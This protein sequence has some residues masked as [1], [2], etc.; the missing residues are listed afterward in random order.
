MNKILLSTAFISLFCLPSQA[1]SL[2]QKYESQ[3]TDPLTYTCYRAGGD[4]KIDGKLTESS[5]QKAIPTA[6]FADISGKGFAKPK[7]T[8]TAKIL[9]D[10]NYLYIGAVIKE[11]DIE[12][13]LTHRDDIVF[14]DNDFEI[15]L[16]PDGDGTEYFEI[17]TNAIGTIFDL[18]LDRAYRSN[19]NFFTQWNCPGIKLAVYRKGT[20]NN[21]ADE[22]DYWSV[23]IAIPHD[24][25]K[26][27]FNN[28]LKQSRCW[29]LNFSR[30][31][32]LKKKGPEENW[33]WSPTGKID[34][35]MPERWGYVYLVDAP[36]GSP[37]QTVA[38]PYNKWIYKLLWAM[39]YAQQ[40]YYG[41][42]HHYLNS[43]NDFA[44]TDRELG[45]L[46]K[47]TQVIDE[48]TQNTF[49]IRITD[50]ENKKCYRLNNEGKFTIDKISNVNQ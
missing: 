29:R 18:L 41:T 16:D 20:L 13:K 22:D 36:V 21:A 26:V 45:N 33:V 24:A 38:L 46:P 30:V 37:Q 1:Q 7:Y 17:E 49:E 15:F 4:I 23:E 50:P 40:D 44:L 48:A 28:S 34:M 11:K 42:H 5:W 27:S 2:F 14:H 9:W 25:L 3:L 35:H 8:T 47:N 31:E 6:E 43:V 19:G 39:F 10:D 32:W 12:A